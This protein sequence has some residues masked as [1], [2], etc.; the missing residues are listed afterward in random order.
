MQSQNKGSVLAVM[1]A[2]VVAI[3]FLL[4]LGIRSAN[5]TAQVTAFPIPVAVSNTITP[6]QLT[7]DSL[8]GDLQNLDTKMGGLDTYQNNIN[9]AINDKP[10]DNGL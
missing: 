5:K 7:G 10:V 1:V 4:M 3:G 9:N 6:P 2:T 8:D